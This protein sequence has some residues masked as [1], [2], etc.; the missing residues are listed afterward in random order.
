M[1][2]TGQH[3]A[4]TRESTL[5][6]MA[7]TRLALGLGSLWLRLLLLDADIAMRATQV[8]L[9]AVGRRE[10]VVELAFCLRPD[11]QCS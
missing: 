5:I 7:L 3:N 10:L 9:N 4:A 11:R 1:V 6:R 2:K 8:E